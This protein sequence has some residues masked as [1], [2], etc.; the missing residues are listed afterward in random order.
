MTVYCTSMSPREYAD[1][2]DAL[3]RAAAD[4][5]DIDDPRHYSK[6]DLREIKRT[7]ARFRA[8]AARLTEA[9]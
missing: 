1:V 3:H 6:A 7:A 4:A 5:E 9:K 8:L 2:I